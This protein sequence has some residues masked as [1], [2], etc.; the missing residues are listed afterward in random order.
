[1]L[2]PDVL[3]IRIIIT[4][5]SLKSILFVLLKWLPHTKSTDVY[6]QRLHLFY[7]LVL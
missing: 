7:I 1:M 3:G 6:S 4:S 2:S 5:K